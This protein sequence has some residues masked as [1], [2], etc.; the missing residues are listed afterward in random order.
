MHKCSAAGACKVLWGTSHPIRVN[1]QFI[2]NSEEARR[3]LKASV[4]LCSNHLEFRGDRP[5]PYAGHSKNNHWH[6]LLGGSESDHGSSK[7]NVRTLFRLASG[8]GDAVAGMAGGYCAALN[9]QNPEP[10]PSPPPTR[11]RASGSHRTGLSSV[12]HPYARATRS[13]TT[14]ASAPPLSPFVMITTP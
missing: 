14:C 10:S 1:E 8:K 2:P 11:T 6:A 9:E 4:T 5:L 12:S 3:K 7:D 13:R